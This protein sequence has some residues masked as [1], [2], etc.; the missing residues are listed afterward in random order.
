MLS[1]D[2]YSIVLFSDIS[3]KKIIIE[4]PKKK[5][6]RGWGNLKSKL[7]FILFTQSAPPD[8]PACR[9]TA[10]SYP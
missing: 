7:R 9:D 6:E 2:S 1:T 3:K 4:I 10:L 5:V 8:Q